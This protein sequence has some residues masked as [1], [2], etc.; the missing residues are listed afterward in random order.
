MVGYLCQVED[1]EGNSFEIIYLF[2]TTRAISSLITQ[3]F[4]MVG[5]IFQSF[6][7]RFYS[8]L[9]MQH[10]TEW[11]ILGL[12]AWGIIPQNKEF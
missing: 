6:E 7:L 4:A 10:S 9:F 2:Q 8:H 11:I 12:G 1:D 3:Y 5:V